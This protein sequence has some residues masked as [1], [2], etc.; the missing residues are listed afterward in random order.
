MIAT[1]PPV[2]TALIAS[3]PRMKSS[4]SEIEIR[5]APRKKRGWRLSCGDIR[6]QARRPSAV[7]GP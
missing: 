2:A 4:D 7:R 1:S 5:P 3:A 6:V